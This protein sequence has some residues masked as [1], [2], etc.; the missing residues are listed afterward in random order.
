MGGVC[1]GEVCILTNGG[2]ILIDGRFRLID[3]QILLLDAV[4]CGGGT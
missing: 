3:R 4:F 2:V 1:I